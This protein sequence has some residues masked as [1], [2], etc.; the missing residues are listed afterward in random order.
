MARRMRDLTPVQAG[1]HH[2]RVEAVGFAQSLVR[3]GEGVDEPLPRIARPVPVDRITAAGDGHAEVVDEGPPTVA[4]LQLVRALVDDVDTQQRQVR[5]D[6]GQR[7]RF[8]TTED[9]EPQVRL[10]VGAVGA[11]HRHGHVRLAVQL[12]QRLE[13]EHPLLGG[14]VLLVALGQRPDQGREVLRL[15]GG[16]HDLG[17]VVVPGTR[18]LGELAF[19]RADVDVAHRLAHGHPDHEVQS[20]Q[21]RLADPRR[22]VDR[23]TAQLAHQDVLHPVPDRRRVPV[24]R[25]VDQAVEEPPVRIAPQE[26]PDLAPLLEVGDLLHACR[27]GRPSGPGTT[28]PAA[29]CPTRP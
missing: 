28:R 27:P 29:T 11:V 21:D 26:Q 4:E 24:A 13:I 9:L 19:Q 25:Q 6:L 2:Q 7:Q 8:P 17:E 15:L 16:V 14:V 20:G 1:R 10:V 18:G 5:H 3:G 23:G 12:G 22:V